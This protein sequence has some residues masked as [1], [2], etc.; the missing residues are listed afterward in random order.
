MSSNRNSLPR[1]LAPH[2]AREILGH[3]SAAWAYCHRAALEP[4][5]PRLGE[6]RKS[7]RLH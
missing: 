4:P 7:S 5:R 1:D 2:G 3:I 6:M